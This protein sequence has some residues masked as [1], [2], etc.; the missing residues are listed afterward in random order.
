M[1]PQAD[2]VVLKL[3]VIISSSANPFHS[4]HWELLESVDWACKG[5]VQTI[6]SRILVLGNLNSEIP[7]ERPVID[8]EFRIMFISARTHAERDVDYLLLSQPLV[9]LVRM[10][11]LATRCS[12]DFVRPGIWSDVAVHLTTKPAGYYSVVHL[13]VHG[14][15]HDGKS[16]LLF[17]SA[18]PGI[19]LRA[20]SH[21]IAQD[22]VRAQVQIVVLN[23]CNSA[24]SRES[25]RANLA[26]ALIR[27]GISTVVAMSY[28]MLS[29]SADILTRVFYYSILVQ[30]LGIDKS[31]FCGRMALQ[32]S[33][34]RRGRFGEVR[35][36]RDEFVP[37]IYKSYS[38]A[39][40]WVASRCFDPL[41]NH[42]QSAIFY[43]KTRR[44]LG[45]DIDTLNLEV[46][47]Y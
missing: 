24:T 33:K 19:V 23:A 35:R 21:N 47:L 34:N 10:P 15:V 28:A 36:L 6:V 8:D 4:L 9:D 12:I 38:G 17:A 45:R 29:E 40:R 27:S 5:K 41:V 22:I 26:H 3:A 18:V 46:I 2:D 32:S 11:T 14:V 44:S 25:H 1:L 13:D 42:S 20:A 31:I 39:L 30:G 43:A 16:M 37:V 7:V